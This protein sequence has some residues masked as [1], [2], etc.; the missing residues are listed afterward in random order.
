MECTVQITGI[1]VTYTHQQAEDSLQV[2]EIIEFV[3][4]TSKVKQINLTQKTYNVT[5]NSSL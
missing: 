5:Q 3:G 2:F 1:R 4:F